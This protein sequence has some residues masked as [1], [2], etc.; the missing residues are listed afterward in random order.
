MDEQSRSADPVIAAEIARRAA[1]HERFAFDDAAYLLGALSEEDRVAFED[2]LHSCPLCQSD[3]AELAPVPE[4]LAQV[5][6]SA[7]T[8]EPPPETLL[9]RL[10]HEIQ[11]DRRRRFVR[12]GLAGL[13]AACLIAV[14]TAVGTGVW[15]A[16]HT[17]QVVAMQAVGAGTV[18]VHATVKL[19]S[20]K[21]GTSIELK[22]TYHAYQPYGPG[23]GGAKIPWYRMVVTNRAGQDLPI[24]TWP[25]PQPGED[26]VVA[27]TT[28]WAKPDIA[29]ITVTQMD[30]TPVLR[31]DL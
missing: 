24:G 30:G 16:E 22:C 12:G 21:A 13:A 10:L 15:R 5:D 26:V 27:R 9:P 1:E 23:A 6:P 2:H 28:H 29:R 25:A 3:L 20:S 14:L 4:L 18:P 19:T 17:P 11:R 7:W 31:L 8:A